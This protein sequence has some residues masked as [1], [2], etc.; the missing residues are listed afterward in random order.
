VEQ[1]L[2]ERARH[3]LLD[4]PASDLQQLVVFHARWAGGFAGAAGQAAIQVS[5][6]AGPSLKTFQQLFD[7]IDT[8]TR[9]IQFVP[10]QLIGGTGGIAET[11]VHTAAQDPIGFLTECSTAV[12]FR[13][14]GLHL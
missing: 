6:Y 5:L 2:Q 10:Q 3:L 4:Q 8:P 1:A 12:L 13:N 11:A 14:P 7:L 9:P